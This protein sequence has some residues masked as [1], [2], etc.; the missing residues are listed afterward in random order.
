MS[1]PQPPRRPTTVD[2][3]AKELGTILA[4]MNVPEKHR[5]LGDA[6]TLAWLLRKLHVGN[7]GHPSLGRALELLR[8]ISDYRTTRATYDSGQL[9]DRRSG[10]DRR[11]PKDGP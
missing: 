3:L 1:S 6:V 8:R 9:P 5:D 2:D 11:A 10:F 4:G 7:P